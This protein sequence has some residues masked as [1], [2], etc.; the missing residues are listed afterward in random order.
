MNKNKTKS[1]SSVFLALLLVLSL[2]GGLNAAAATDNIGELIPGGMAFG[3]K[4]F[5][6]GAVV[7]GTTGVE[8]ASGVVSPA[9]DAGLKS[10]DIIVRAGGK[11]FETAN[12]LI[13]LISGSGGKPISIAYLRDGKEDTVT[14]TPARD[15]ANG[16]YRIGVLVRDST[17]GIGTVTF[18]DPETLDFGGLGHGI[19]DNETGTLLPLSR[20]AVV[21][22]EITDVVKSERNSPGELRGKFGR[23]LVG[24]LWDNTEQ[25]VFGRLSEIPDTAYEPLPVAARGELAEGEATILTTLADGN[26][27]EYRIEIEHIYSASGTTKNFLIK[28]TDERL[29]DQAG[30]IVQG[31]SGS[32]IIQNGKLVGA[33]THVLIDDPLHGYGICIENMLGSAFD[34]SA[35]DEATLFAA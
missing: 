35:R 20:G 17:A 33:V 2:S 8:T 15:T 34:V 24:E 6:D 11:E 19:Y 27:G 10:G 22:V 32:P 3:V 14:V 21:E 5:T 1:V 7:L 16:S 28:V 26:I 12:E 31:M 29:I 18:I 23:V 4:F 9:K 25:G 30:G 13:S